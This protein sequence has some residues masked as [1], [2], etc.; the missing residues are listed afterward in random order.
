MFMGNSKAP[1]GIAD[2]YMWDYRK[3]YKEANRFKYMVYLYNEAIKMGCAEGH[4]SLA[5]CY[6]EGWG[7]PLSYK[8]AVEELKKAVAKNSPKGLE[9]YGTHLIDV[10]KREEEGRD[11]LGLTGGRP[12]SFIEQDIYY[13][14]IQKEM[15]RYLPLKKPAKSTFGSL[16]GHIYV[17]SK[18]IIVD[19]NYAITGSA[20]INE[21][22][23]WHDSEVALGFRASAGASV[24]RDMLKTLCQ[25]HFG[26]D[27]P[28]GEEAF[29]EFSGE[30][31][32]NS[33]IYNQGSPS[34]ALEMRALPLVMR[35][36]ALAGLPSAS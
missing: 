25:E 10:E 20:N 29:K 32:D 7:V 8:K 23:M 1:L 21:R 14:R 31:D 27:P 30:L 6:S 9:R 18:L 34:A 4:V 15:A 26:M 35:E 28:E 3:K 11:F 16:T 22:S 5:Q 12:K 13:A 24:P 33:R 2:I 36:T 17:H 19:G